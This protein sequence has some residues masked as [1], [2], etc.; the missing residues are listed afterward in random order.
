MNLLSRIII[1]VSIL[2]AIL[3]GGIY[4]AQPAYAAL[5]DGA[6]GEACRG[7]ALDQN[8]PAGCDPAAG[9]SL[10]SILRLMLNLLSI[11]VGIIAI[12][13]M[14]IAGVKFMTSQGEASAVAAA[15]NTLLY[16]IIGLVVVALAQF[17]VRFVL[18]RVGV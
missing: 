16:A 10:N 14:I 1:G 18:S 13:M 15:R 9:T 4:A 7:V 5:F 8:A 17:I 2:I 11:I 3:A 12:I 6:K